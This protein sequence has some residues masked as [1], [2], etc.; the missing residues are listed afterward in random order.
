MGAALDDLAAIHDQDDVGG[1]DGAEAVGDDDAGAV[2]HDLF[3]RVLNQRLGL[4]IEAAGGFVQHQNA[5]VFQ[6]DAGNRQ[7]LFL[8]AA[9]AV[10]TLADDSVVAVVQ[11]HDEVVNV[12]RARRRF[13]LRLSG[14]HVG[15]EQI[16]ADG[17]VEQ[18]GFLR[19]HAD[20][21]G[22]RVEPQVAQVMAVD[23]DASGRRV[24][25]TRDEIGH[26]RLA[27]ATRPHQRRQLAG[28]E[29]ERDVVQRALAGLAANHSRHALVAVFGGRTRVAR[30]HRADVLGAAVAA[31]VL[32]E[33]V[34]VHRVGEA[35]VLEDQLAAHVFQLDGVR[36]L[37]DLDRQIGHF[38][39]A[40]EADH[41]G[42]EIDRG[43]GE[44]T[45][46][47]VELGQ[48]GRKGDDG[49][50]R[51]DAIQHQMAADPVDQRRPDDA[52]QTHES[53]E[54]RADDCPAH[55]DIAHAGGAVAEA[56]DFDLL[57]AEQLDQQRAADVERFAH[58]GVHIGVVVHRLAGDIAQLK[59]DTARR[60]DEQR[61]DHQAEQ[62][63]PPF[64]RQHHQQR[65]DQVDGIG[66]DADEGVA[67]GGLGSDDVVVEAAHQLAG[68]GVGEEAQRHA[69]HV[70]V[71]EAAQVVNDAF[72][73]GGVILARDDANSAGDNGN[74]HEQN[75]QPVE[76]LDIAVRQ[77]VVD[78]VAQNERRHQAEAGR[79][80]DQ[81][82]R[83]RQPPRIGAR[84]SEDAL[85]KRPGQARLVA[86]VDAAVHGAAVIHTHS[87]CSDRDVGWIV[88]DL[89]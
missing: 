72:A 1:E 57:A 38:E 60:Q 55:A 79:N 14:V 18:V 45:Q 6:D 27:R 59:A 74:Q 22:Q 7:S 89:L 4:A 73:N 58:H 17:V 12:G 50:D 25:E 36:L 42:G 68:F 67:D 76:P 20:I 71:E 88:V 81:H 49:A 11:L 15:V 87:P 80:E 34:L 16:G 56:V 5:R 86:F 65:G 26:R 30:Q 21:L 48:V 54:L 63:Q 23:G 78:E 9:Q 31:D 85:Q 3:E 40:L 69:L 29:V 52:D 82:E 47:V 41:R 46:R 51:E 61:E 32:Q 24:V 43:A 28:L 64:Q 35:D 83:Q 33:V 13:D 19:H 77:R 84:E 8:A 62:R 75:G 70:P 53:E 44:V 2:R 37:D 66:D 10:A 39:D